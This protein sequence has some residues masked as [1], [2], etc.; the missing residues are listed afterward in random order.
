MIYSK[1]DREELILH[2]S[3]ITEILN[4]HNIQ[5]WMFA[6]AVL[7][8]VRDRELIPWDPDIDLCYWKEDFLKMISLKKEFKKAGFK[9][10]IKEKSARFDWEG[11]KGQH[12]GNACIELQGDNA[13]REPL[14]TNNKIGRIIYFGFLIRT[15][16]YNMKNTYRFLRWFA[17]KSKGCHGTK[18]VLPAHFYQNLKTI[19]FYGLKIKIPSKTEEYLTYVYGDWKTPKKWDGTPYYY[20]KKYYGT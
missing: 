15:V 3:K 10:F 4:K 1:E 19:D 16:R 13:V 18:L 7:G 14:V 6:G 9:F 8:Y 5:Y 12:I 20:A 11:S 2:L 17:L